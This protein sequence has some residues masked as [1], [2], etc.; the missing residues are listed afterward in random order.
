VLPI[1]R[2]LEGVDAARLIELAKGLWTLPQR[3]N[4]SRLA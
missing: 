4:L 3:E 1:L 2:E